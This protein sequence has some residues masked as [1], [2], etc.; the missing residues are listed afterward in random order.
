MT[1]TQQQLDNLRASFEKWI[2]ETFT[3]VEGEGEDVGDVNW[4]LIIGEP[5]WGRKDV[6]LH[7]TLWG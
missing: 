6:E 4:D 7:R 3:V 5:K 1:I 2:G